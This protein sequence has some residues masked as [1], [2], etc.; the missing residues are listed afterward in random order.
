ML[1]WRL[2]YPILPTDKTMKLKKLPFLLSLG[3]FATT[4]LMA[5]DKAAFDPK[6]ARQGG[7]APPT[8]IDKMIALDA[9]LGK[10]KVNWSSVWTKYQLDVNPNNIQDTDVS[11]PIL[12]G[13][14]MS[15]GVLAIKAH[16]AEKLNAVASDIEKLAK[17]LNVSDSELKR[18]KTVQMYAGRNEWPRVFLELGYLQND[19]LRTL[20]KDSNN[21][22]RALLIAA[23]WLHGLN[24]ISNVINDQ[25]NQKASAILREPLLIE[26]LLADLEKLKPEKKKSKQAQLLITELKKIKVLVS[27]PMRA[28]VPQ[29]DVESIAFITSATCKNLRSLAK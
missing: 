17:K 7:L 21:D 14:R 11:I 19:V 28:E 29:K 25:K 10:N 27:V 5:Q 2:P 1:V 6:G 26:A 24:A 18:A 12:L 23:G 4:S 9:M 15:D 3:L 16:D 20:K 22:R 8:P 13:M